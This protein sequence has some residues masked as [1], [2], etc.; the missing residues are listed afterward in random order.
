M[1]KIMVL[2][3]LMLIL[4]GCGNSERY[5]FS[6]S[7]ESWNVFYVVEISGGDREERTGTI[8]FTGAGEAPETIDYKLET[9]SGGSEGTGITVEDGTGNMGNGFCGGC[10]VVQEDEEIEVEITWN[11]QT[12]SLLLTTEK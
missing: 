5:N 12:E 4:S 10:A 1:K 6:G 3:I 7:S 2:G 8:N 9:A 11:G